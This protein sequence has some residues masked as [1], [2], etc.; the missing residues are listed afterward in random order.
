VAG[1]V[2]RDRKRVDRAGRDAAEYHAERGEREKAKPPERT[3][4]DDAMDVWADNVGRF[5]S[6]AESQEI[7][8][9]KWANMD[10]PIALSRPHRRAYAAE[11]AGSGCSGSLFSGGCCFEDSRREGGR[12]DRRTAIDSVLRTFR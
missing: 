11:G 10:R 1:R 9:K 12:N 4:C 7:D 3:R 6:S 2:V 8:S 5:D